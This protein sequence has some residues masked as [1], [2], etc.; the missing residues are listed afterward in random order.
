MSTPEPSARQSISLSKLATIFAVIF[1]LTFGLCSVS[2]FTAHT[3]NQY[4]ITT[5]LVIE[6]IC[7]ACLIVIAIIVIIRALQGD[8]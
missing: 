4:V 7:T 6:A 1:G 3:V 2:T 8:Y 5:A